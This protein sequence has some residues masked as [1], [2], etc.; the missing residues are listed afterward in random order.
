[1]S[2]QLNNQLVLPFTEF[3]KSKNIDGPTAMRILED[4]FRALIRKKFGTDEHFDVVINLDKGDLQLWQV[5][6]VVDDDDA[7]ALEDPANLG[8][9][10]AKLIEP[11]FEVGEEVAEEISIEDFGRRAVLSAKNTLLQKV[12]DLEKDALY[13]KYTE[14]EGQIITAEAHQVFGGA[15][16]LHDQE[17]NNLI[18]PREEQIPKDRFKKGDYIRAVVHRVELKNNTP[19]IVLSRT[20]PVFLERLFESEVPEIADGVI[21]IK[22][23]VRTPGERAKVVVESYDDNIDPVGACVGMQ[24]TR[25][26]GIVR[27]LRNES[28]DVINHTDNF[29]LLIT[30]ALSPARISSIQQEEGR[31]AVYL[32][33]D[34]VSLAIG[35]GGQNIQLASRLV[36]QEI[37]VYRE[38][39]NEEDVDLEEFTDE[40]H[41]DVLAAFQKAGLNSAKKILE[42]DPQELTA[43]TGLDAKTIDEAC[44]V[45]QREFE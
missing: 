36:E 13:Q 20:S 12:R 19:R 6:T 21:S 18:L 35:K 33:P 11:D 1:M 24:G 15:T 2:S 22:K 14:L 9:S 28:I 7:E 43:R 17:N 30:R 41:E 29:E 3:A 25:I 45:L 37:D 38:L 34:Q 8:L 40:I 5:R 32:K 42:V 23:I 26:H 4:V 16:I 10:A 27:E 44:H 39:D 31:V